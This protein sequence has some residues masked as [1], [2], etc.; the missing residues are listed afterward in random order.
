LNALL[1]ARYPY[2]I[3]KHQELGPLLCAAAQSQRDAYYRHW[4]VDLADD[5]DG[6]LARELSHAS[7]SPFGTFFLGVM[8]RTVMRMTTTTTTTWGSTPIATVPIAGPPGRQ[9]D[10]PARPMLFRLEK[11]ESRR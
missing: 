7:G 1:K 4:F 6:V 2:A 3:Q 8:E 10:E 9:R 11:R 5:L